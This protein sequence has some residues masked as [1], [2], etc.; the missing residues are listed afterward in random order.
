MNETCSF[1]TTTSN[2]ILSYWI[3]IAKVGCFHICL[4]F[5]VISN[6]HI[7]SSNSCGII[8]KK[9]SGLDANTFLQLLQHII[10]DDVYYYSVNCAILCFNSLFIG[11]CLGR[12]LC[13]NSMFIDMC[14]GRILIFTTFPTSVHTWR[15]LIWPLRLFIIVF[16]ILAFFKFLISRHFFAVSDR[17]EFSGRKRFNILRPLSIHAFF[18]NFQ[19][20]F[21]QQAALLQK[22]KAVLL[23]R[24]RYIVICKK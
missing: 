24:N 11:M 9:L 17:R 1:L 20:T 18:S 23:D 15:S 19:R 6:G 16:L 5:S 13:F 22:Q 10:L 3:K 14:L 8:L 2:F 21:A 7:L 4:V 12:I